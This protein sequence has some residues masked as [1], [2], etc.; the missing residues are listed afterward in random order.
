MRVID[1][2]ASLD[3]QTYDALFTEV[4]EAAG[5]KLLL[6]GRHLRWVD[7]NGMVGLLAAGSVGRDRSGEEPILE[8]GTA[9]EVKSYL[10]RMGFFQAA[11]GIFSLYSATFSSVAF[12]L[13]SA[14]SISF[15]KIISTAPLGPMTAISD[16][17]HA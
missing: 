14:F 6:N 17:G 1:L 15:L 3:F 7:P 5:E 16:D 4:V 9:G 12:S 11:E 10:G 8:L 2:P 13:S